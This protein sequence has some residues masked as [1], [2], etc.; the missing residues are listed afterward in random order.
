M[1]DTL[2]EKKFLLDK[3]HITIE[4]CILYIE[5]YRP[6]KKQW[7]YD[8]CITERTESGKPLSWITIRKQ[9]YDEIFPDFGEMTKRMK[10]FS[11]WNMEGNTTNNNSQQE[12]KK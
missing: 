1:A 4:D 10:L 6:D 12:E 9:F 8:K 11:A 2:L 5:Q 7:F 3:K